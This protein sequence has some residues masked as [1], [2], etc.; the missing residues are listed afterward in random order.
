MPDYFFAGVV[1][2][3]ILWNRSVVGVDSTD[4][5]DNIHARDPLA[6]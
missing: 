3:N 2:G 1:L 6:A 5:D 4:V